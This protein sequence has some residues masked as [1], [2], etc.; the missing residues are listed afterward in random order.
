MDP[1]HLLHQL[2]VKPITAQEEKLR[3]RHP[4]VPAARKLQWIDYK[5]DVKYSEDQS[6]IRLF[7]LRSSARPF[8]MDLPRLAWVRL[9]RLRTLVLEDSS[10]PCTNGDLLLQ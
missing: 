6:K 2:M 1:K 8:G 7:V 5:W 10:H 3:S 9:N 4:F